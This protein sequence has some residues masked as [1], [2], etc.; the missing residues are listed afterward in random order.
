ML[1]EYES[2]LRGHNIKADELEKWLDH[3][4]E[5]LT[6]YYEQKLTNFKQDY[7]FGFE[8]E[9]DFGHFNPQVEGISITGKMDKIVFND[10]KKQT[11][12]IVDYKSGKP[13][14]VKPGESL[15]R[16]LVFYDVLAKHSAGI[17]WQ[18][19]ECSIEFLTPDTNGK[20]GGRTLKVSREDREAVI[21]ELK[22][23]HEAVMNLEFPLIDTNGMKEDQRQEID[24]WQNFGQW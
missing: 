12:T 13:K 11:A 10:A 6:N 9:Y 2:A 1:T 5:I 3:G 16:Q 4:R 17:N 15:W 18:V 24:Y 23:A 21:K 22:T 20:L 8:L 19:S 14:P 7:P